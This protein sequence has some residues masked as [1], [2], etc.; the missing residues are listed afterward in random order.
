MESFT[1]PELL[2]YLE[3]AKNLVAGTAAYDAMSKY[4]EE[5]RRITAQLN[6]GYHSPEQIR[7]FMAELTGRP[8]PGDLRIFPPFYSDFGKNIYFGANVFVNS[9]CCFQDQGKITIG[10]NTLIGHQVVIATIN[11]GLAP[12]LRHHHHMAPVTIGK[13]VWIGSGSIILPGVTIGDG[14][15]IGAGSLVTKNVEENTVVAGNPARFIR[16]ATQQ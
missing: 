6:S 14:A 1:L 4:S 12:D 15:I 2:E 7:M 5:A 9:C 3:S 11:H 10:D 13:D 8:V 16:A